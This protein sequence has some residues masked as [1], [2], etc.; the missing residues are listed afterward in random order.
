MAENIKNRGTIGLLALQGAYFAHQKML[1][2]LGASTKLVRYPDEL[3][4]V[5]AI[6][7]PGGESTT[8][9]KMLERNGFGDKLVERVKDGM[10]YFGT[11][12]GA[13]LAAG[14]ATNPAQESLRLIDISV[15]RNAYGR[16]VDSFVADFPLPGL[17]IEIFHGVF[18]RA[19]VISRVGEGIEIL[20]EYR[21]HPVLIRGGNILLA[22]FHPELSGSTAV[23]EYFL[24]MVGTS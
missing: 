8:I 2:I 9:L 10:P 22:T 15:K 11:C 3:D 20:A 21:G 23:H 12:A 6:V 13:I 5:D 17:D 1:Q 16:Q 19:P 7:V 24:R 18:I 14:E 4:E